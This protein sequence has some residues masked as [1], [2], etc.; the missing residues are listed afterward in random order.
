VNE[1]YKLQLRDDNGNVSTFHANDWAS[2]ETFGE[3]VKAAAVA[4]GYERF[5]A[6]GALV[7]YDT[8]ET[9]VAR[10]DRSLG[11]ALPNHGLGR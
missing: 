10:T 5:D 11:W 9:V 2:V 4:P 6:D 8:E 3:L 1:L 7:V